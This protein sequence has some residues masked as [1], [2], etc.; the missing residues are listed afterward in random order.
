MGNIA[1]AGIVISGIMDGTTISY[2]VLAVDATGANVPLVQHYNESIIDPDWDAMAKGSAQDNNLL[3]RIVIKATDTATQQ[4]LDG[5][6]RIVS[7]QYNG[8]T[9]EFGDDG[10]SDNVMPGVLKKET[11]T[12]GGITRDCIKFVGNPAAGDPGTHTDQLELTGYVT[13]E[14]GPVNF[15]GLMIPIEIFEVTSAD[16][17]FSANIWTPEGDQNIQAANGN[18][19]RRVTFYKGVKE[20]TDGSNYAVKWFDI[21]GDTDVLLVNGQGGFIISTSDAAK[22]AG[23]TITIPAAA[24]NSSMTIAARI[25]KTS[26]L[27]QDGT[28]PSGVLPIAAD[29]DITYD[30]SDPFQI[31]W[32]V[33]DSLDGSGVEVECER[34]Q[35][36]RFDLRRGW[37]KNFFPVV[38]NTSGDVPDNKVAITFNFDDAKDGS[39]ITG[40]ATGQTD[41][42]GSYFAIS[43]SDV[44]TPAGRRS[45]V[46]HAQATITL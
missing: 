42:G 45:I 6:V 44:V 41:T 37:T 33:R 14:S 19:K 29:T 20:V 2:S 40:I 32:I 25:Y 12:F 7:V 30:F 43:Y 16:E 8:F 11:V 4:V 18:T 24:V 17:G 5:Q 46:A 1:N 22:P 39:D 27:A 15:K 3:P 10:V 13:T 36:P 28:I 23:D 34:G 9:V 26:D 38:Y 31:R 21:T 35:Y